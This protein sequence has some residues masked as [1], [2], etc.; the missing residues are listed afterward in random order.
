MSIAIGIVTISDRASTGEYEDKSGPA[1]RDVLNRW[2]SG[3][4][5]AIVRVVPDEREQIESTL[6][7]L[8]DVEGC[9]LVVTTGGP[10]PAPRDV[11]PEA[12]AAVCDRVLPG[13]GQQMLAVTV[14]NEPTAIL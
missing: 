6:R 5:N 1:I 9:A 7:E 10:G 11:T 14:N 8:S 12:T 13:Y 2:L 3:D 4:W